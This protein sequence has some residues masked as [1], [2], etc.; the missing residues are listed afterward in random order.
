MDIY[1]NALQ[2]KLEKFLIFCILYLINILFFP[3]IQQTLK[4]INI[5]YFVLKILLKS[6]MPT[7][8]PTKWTNL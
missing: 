5:N 6:K 4:Y 7:L 1:K 2:R 8:M 3:I